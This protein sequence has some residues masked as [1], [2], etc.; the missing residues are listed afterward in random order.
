[1]RSN[2]AFSSQ[3]GPIQSLIPVTSEPTLTCDDEESFCTH[4]EESLRQNYL[5]HFSEL[6]IVRSCA[7]IRY[8]P[9]DRFEVEHDGSD[10]EEARLWFLLAVP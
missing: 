3:H 6:L 7:E 2:R 10:V 1:M 4:L 5:T 8:L 9:W